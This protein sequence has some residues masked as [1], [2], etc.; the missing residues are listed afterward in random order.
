MAAAKAIAKPG[1]ADVSVSSHRLNAIIIVTVFLALLAR[2][3]SRGIGNMFLS[4]ILLFARSFYYL[5]LFAFWGVSVRARVIQPAARKYLTA[6]ASM[7]VIWLIVKEFKW[8]FLP[9]P[10]FQ[11]Y[12]WYIYYIPILLIPLLTLFIAM[13]L[14]KAGEYRLSK[15]HYLL[16][17]PVSFL[18]LAVLTN[19]LHCLV[20]SF[21]S[22]ALPKTDL[23]SSYGPLFF[24]IVLW[25]L[26]LA[27]TAL[28]V[29]VYKLRVPGLKK[30][31]WIPFVPIALALI[32]VLLYATGHPL[33]RG[34]L[35]D[36]AVIH[37]LL[38]T[39]VLESCIQ[40]GLIQSNMR[41]L[42]LFRASEDISARIT[43][44]DYHVRYSA[45]KAVPLS[46]E[47]M[48]RAL[49]S[50]IVSKEGI[51]IHNMPVNGGHAVWTEDIKDLM[52]REDLLREKQE[53]LKERNQ[54]L[55]LEY[56]REKSHRI[57]E[58]QNRLY[59]L[60]Q[61]KT[62]EQFDQIKTLVEAYEKE[63]KEEDRKRI[64][65][66]IIVLGSFIKRRRDFVLSTDAS[67]MIPESMLKSAL[68]ESFRAMKIYGIKG[69]YHVNTG[70]EILPGDILA[71]AYDF[72]EESLECVLGEAEY[73]N[74]MVNGQGGKMRIS[75][76]CDKTGDDEKLMK[77]YPDMRVER[78]EDG[79]EYILILKIEE[80]SGNV[81]ES[82]KIK[83]EPGNVQKSAKIRESAVD[84]GEAHYPGE[85][86]NLEG[87]MP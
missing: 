42:D 30:Y 62:Q 8:R 18:I 57:V 6:I 1:H 9:A 48:K 66:H 17:A 33:I 24:V 34:I 20:F 72:F 37:C 35:G 64:L 58:E 82:L 68:A 47:D 11:R 10:L 12:L 15:N 79:V 7:E 28:G 55:Q 44:K 39:G 25:S 29:M 81:Q 26:L 43:D 71:G 3:F 46:V 40:C 54:L 59:D 23:N 14:G 84:R 21:P 31:M 22:S 73:L 74:V 2:I 61:K 69:S 70:K 5:G 52:E 41:Y 76:L 53:E 83:E 50:P 75:V 49:D 56:E 80:G 36:V 87:D 86:S 67:P 85:G 19:D 45:A 27:L 51:R 32:Y 4:R 16:Y 77:K 60:L 38:Y 78:E 63:E 65:A 13:S